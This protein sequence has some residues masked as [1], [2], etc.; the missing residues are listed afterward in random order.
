ML[1]QYGFPVAGY[2]IVFIAC[3]FHSNWIDYRDTSCTVPHVYTMLCNGWDIAEEK[4]V[5]VT[6]PF[7][8]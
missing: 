1:A 6:L 4:I 2:C 5:M 3:I 8:N 7:N